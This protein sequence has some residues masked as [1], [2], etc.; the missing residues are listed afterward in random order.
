[1]FT[2]GGLLLS[3]DRYYSNLRVTESSLK[4]NPFFGVEYPYV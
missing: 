4:L 1:M 2:I 3:G